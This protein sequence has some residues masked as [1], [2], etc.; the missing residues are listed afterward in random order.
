MS[1][2]PDPELVDRAV[3]MLPGLGWW[4]LAHLQFLATAGGPA[5]IDVNVHFYGSLPLA[6]VAGVNLP[7]IWH[8]VSV[9]GPPAPPPP[10]ALGSPTAGFK[11]IWLQRARVSRGGWRRGL[12]VEVREPCGPL[13]TRCPGCCSRSS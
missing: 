6:T 7:A 13:T 5:L 11:A 4:G 2:E 12:C 9:R 3:N 8:R 10:T 1:V